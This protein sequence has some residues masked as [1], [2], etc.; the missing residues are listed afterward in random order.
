MRHFYQE[1]EPIDCDHGYQ[2]FAQRMARWGCPFPAIL[3]HSAMELWKYSDDRDAG[4]YVES[5]CTCHGGP[6]CCGVDHSCWVGICDNCQKGNWVGTIAS[7]LMD[8]FS[9][10]SEFRKPENWR[11]SLTFRAGY[12]RLLRAQLIPAN[13]VTTLVVSDAEHAACRGVYD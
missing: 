8:V 3:S 5:A 7:E 13:G 9:D 11:T 6:E 1:D 12:N 10:V 4:I 2:S